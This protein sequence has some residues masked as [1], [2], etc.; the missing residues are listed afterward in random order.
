MNK[1]QI[2]SLIVTPMVTGCVSFIASATIIITILRS[3]VKLST[4]YR[5]MVFMIS[6]FDLLQSLS[7]LTGS[8]TMPANTG[9]LAIGNDLTCSLQGFFAVLGCVGAMIYT[10]TLTVYFFLVIK[11][12]MN[13]DAIEKRFEPFLHAFPL[14]YATSISVYI[15]ATKN[16]NPAG[17]VCWIAS[18]PTNCRNNPDVDCESTGDPDLLKWISI[19]G[20]LFIFFALNCMILFCICN[21]VFTQTKLSQ[22]YRNSWVASS[23]ARPTPEQDQGSS[24]RGYCPSFCCLTKKETP[25]PLAARLSRPSRASIQRLQ[26]LSAR[27]IAYIVGFV[28][29][30]MFTL[31]Y[32][33]LDL[34][35]NGPVPFTLIFL[36]RFFYPL[37]GLFNILVFTYPHV[38]SYRRNHVSHSWFQAFWEVLKSG[39]DSDQTRTGRGRRNSTSATR[40]LT[41][42]PE[43]AQ[44]RKSISDFPL[45]SATPNLTMNLSSTRPDFNA[46]TKLD[47]N[48]DISKLEAGQQVLCPIDDILNPSQLENVDESH[49][50]DKEDEDELENSRD[51]ERND[52]DVSNENHLAPI[53]YEEEDTLLVITSS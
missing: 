15:F 2:T 50:N 10:F 36:S 29:T 47:E 37:Q 31:I 49:S 18:R 25:S 6:L 16:Y 43:S 19:G 8:F 34:Y 32:R 35:G 41:S 9:W 12:E 24:K 44:R 48:I 45:K 5:R 27:A 46:E 7:Q 26:E 4:I 42:L 13:E 51:E 20:P 39:G 14:L 21:K 1:A 23:P 11:I 3:N 28:V 38:V 30:Y 33:L 22:A 53:H 40:R 52:L 17:P